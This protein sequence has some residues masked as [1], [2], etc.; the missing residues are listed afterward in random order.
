V[1]VAAQAGYDAMHA[2][3]L[4]VAASGPTH[5]PMPPLPTRAEVMAAR[6]RGLPEP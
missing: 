2:L 1:L 3:L 6:K 4:A 5:P